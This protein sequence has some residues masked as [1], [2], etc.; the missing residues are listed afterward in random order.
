MLSFANEASELEQISGGLNIIK[1]MGLTVQD[2]AKLIEDYMGSSFFCELSP[3]SL[4]S[5]LT[6]VVQCE[7]L[8]R[9]F[10]A[11]WQIEFKLP[12]YVAR[13]SMSNLTV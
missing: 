7:L 3:E 1:E 9:P 10:Q 2:G 11:P 13:I 4:H 8:N 12:S 6:A 5:Q